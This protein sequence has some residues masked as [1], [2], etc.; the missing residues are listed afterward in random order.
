MSVIVLILAILGLGFLTLLWVSVLL[1]LA[2]IAWRG[3][4]RTTG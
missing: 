2:R 4:F 3:V 1:S